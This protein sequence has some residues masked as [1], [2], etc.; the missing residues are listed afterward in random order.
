MRNLGGN[1]NNAAP[2]KVRRSLRDL[3]R[4]HAQGHVEPLEQ[5]M[6]AWQGLTQMKPQELHAHFFCL[7]PLDKAQLAQPEYEPSFTTGHDGHVLFPTWHRVYVLKLE[8]LLQTFVPDVTLPFWDETSVES[9]KWGLPETLT[10]PTFTFSNGETI[11]NPLRTT[12]LPPVENIHSATTA[13]AKSTTPLDMTADVTADSSTSSG[14]EGDAPDETPSSPEDPVSAL[15]ATIVSWLNDTPAGGTRVNLVEQYTACL[16]AP[17]FVL[18]S[19]TAS[20]EWYNTTH[21]AHHV[22]SLE[23]VHH[24]V[25]LAVQ[26]QWST[27]QEYAPVQTKAT[28]A[29]L[30]LD[31]LFFLHLCFIDYV[32]WTWQKKHDLV[33][34]TA[35]SKKTVMNEPASVGS[36][37]ATT[38]PLRGSLAH[39]VGTQD[40]KAALW[41]LHSPLQPFAVPVGYRAAAAR[42][43]NEKFY[44]RSKDVI[45]IETQLGY[46]YGPGSLDSEHTT[47][48]DNVSALGDSI[49]TTNSTDQSIRIPT[50]H[51]KLIVSGLDYVIAK[52]TTSTSSSSSLLLEA[53]A[54][55]KGPKGVTRECLGYESIVTRAS[56]QRRTTSLTSIRKSQVAIPLALGLDPL[57]YARSVTLQVTP[58]TM[59]TTTPVTP[60]TTPEDTI[61]AT[62]TSSLSSTDSVT[63]V[64]YRLKVQCTPGNRHIYKAVVEPSEVLQVEQAQQ[65]QRQESAPL[66]VAP[67]A[68]APTETPVTTPTPIA[69][70]S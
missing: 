11:V 14:E 67:Q 46:N 60:K 57:E 48:G 8:Q 12:L 27:A 70:A 47:T 15:N 54:E 25:H 42:S 34:L 59:T 37:E 19:N 35:Q 10:H 52:N 18:L 53:F 43:K 58:T 24:H 3:E 45:D 2:R 56:S 20:Q 39:K 16:E 62:S 49:R 23:A 40:K 29:N 63:P 6:R 50:C 44:Y 17:N 38:A 13:A 55:W 21:H 41:T 36:D 1:N 33:A 28:A 68:A 64:V 4:M 51:K 69:A 31:P 66:P 61:S 30:V 9:Q 65:Q 26:G 32:F 5:L 22:V 7:S